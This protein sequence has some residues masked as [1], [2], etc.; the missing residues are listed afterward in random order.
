MFH[1]IQQKKKQLL[2]EITGANNTETEANIRNYIKQDKVIGERLL[3]AYKERR[4]NE[5]IVLSP[6]ESILASL[7]TDEKVKRII[8][9]IQSSNDPDGAIRRLVKKKVLTETDVKAIKLRQ[10]LNSN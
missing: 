10:Q 7:P 9:E 1:L 3:N 5:G 2:K 8:P 4:K 6:R